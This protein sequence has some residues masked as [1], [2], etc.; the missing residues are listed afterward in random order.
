MKGNGKG[1]FTAQNTC[2]INFKAL[3]ST[4]YVFKSHVHGHGS[5][6]PFRHTYL[7]C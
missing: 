6:Y 1:L 3:P 5:N 2:H 7:L 4:N